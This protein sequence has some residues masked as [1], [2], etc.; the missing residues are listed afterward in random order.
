MKTQTLLATTVISGLLAFGTIAQAGPNCGQK[1]GG[2]AKY[3]QMTEE[4]K[5]ERMEKRLNR[6]ASKLG[7][8]DEQKTQIQTL[9]QNSR[10]EIF[11]I[12]IDERNMIPKVCND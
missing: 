5:S 7:L 3:S 8:S 2:H 4:Q 11:E 6:M 9:K 1:K 12:L 10:N